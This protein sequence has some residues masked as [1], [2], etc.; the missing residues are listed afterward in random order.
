M[1]AI[2]SYS[3]TFMLGFLPVKCANVVI[4]KMNRLR[5]KLRLMPVWF[6]LSPPMYST[7]GYSSN[8]FLY[9][10]LKTKYFLNINFFSLIKIKIYSFLRLWPI[11]AWLVSPLVVVWGTGGGGDPQ[12]L[13]VFN[14]WDMSHST[15]LTHCNWSDKHLKNK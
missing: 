12:G 9:V 11:P 8:L 5:W 13:I 2:Y 15:L 14:L 4:Q 3:L 1:T 7:Q 6:G 10:H